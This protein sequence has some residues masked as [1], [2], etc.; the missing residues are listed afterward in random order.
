MNEAHEGS[1]IADIPSR[2]GN[3]PNRC[4]PSIPMLEWMSRLFFKNLDLTGV[5][6]P[7]DLCWRTPAK[8]SRCPNPALGSSQI[9]SGCHAYDKHRKHLSDDPSKDLETEPNH[10]QPKCASGVSTKPYGFGH[11]IW[12]LTFECT[13]SLNAYSSQ[14]NPPIPL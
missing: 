14:N 6:G 8:G 5:H 3:S 9:S 2:R 13:N 12:L 10:S 4:I 7:R 1:R 11:V